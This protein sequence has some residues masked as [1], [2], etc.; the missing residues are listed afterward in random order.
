M[1]RVAGFRTS[2]RQFGP[3]L[4]VKYKKFRELISVTKGAYLMMPLGL[5][6][7]IKLQFL[8]A[9]HETKKLLEIII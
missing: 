6:N 7:V 8:K 5:L 1:A 4:T 2:C 3:Y 9:T